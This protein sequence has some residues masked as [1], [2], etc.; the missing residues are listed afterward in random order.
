MSGVAIVAIPCQDDYV[1]KISSEKVP[2]MTLLQLGELPQGSDINR[3]TDFVGHVADTMLH[4]FYMET[5][6]RDVLGPQNADVIF[7]KDEYAKCVEAART[8]MWEQKDIRLAF[9]STQQYDEWTPHLTLGYPA[10]PA[11]EDTRDY[12]GISCVKFD[13]IAV[14]TGDY[15]GAEFRLEPKDDNQLYM[16]DFVGRYLS[17]HGV[18]GMK[19]GVRKAQRNSPTVTIQAKGRKVT[20][21][22][23][24][25][26]PIHSDALEAL[27]GKQV[28]KSSGVHALSNAEL[29]RLVKRL[30]LEQQHSRLSGRKKGAGRSFAEQELKNLGKQKL[31]SVIAKKAAKTAAVAAALA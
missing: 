5:E 28:A 31:S 17:H 15:A 19:W 29:E 18:K 24:K 23:G 16:S 1:W 12:P 11:H 22:G 25:G 30:N 26:H 7:F 21:R 14:W 9:N 10:T 8:A 13:K 27:V 6:Y 4:P 3:I 20:T 2:H